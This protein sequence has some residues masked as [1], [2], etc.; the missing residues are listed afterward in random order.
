MRAKI[1]LVVRDTPGGGLELFAARLTQFAADRIAKKIEGAYTRRWIA[2]KELDFGE[3]DPQ[4]LQ[5]R[6]ELSRG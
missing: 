4:D 2:T 1:Y 3:E 6:R 5:R